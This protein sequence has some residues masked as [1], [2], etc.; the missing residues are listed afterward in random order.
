M[1]SSPFYG[2]TNFGWLWKRHAGFDV[3]T[4]NG[5][6]GN[7]TVY[8]SLGKTPEMIWVK[9]KSES[10]SWACYH[11][12]QNGGTTPWHYY[13]SLNSAGGPSGNS[14]WSVWRQSPNTTRF[15]I[16]DNW[17]ANS[18]SY[19]GYVFASVENICKVGTY[20]GSSSAITVTT[21]FQPR[22]VIIKEIS[23]SDCNGLWVVLDTN[24]G[25]GSGNDKRLD[26]GNDEA[27]VTID[28]G[29]PTSTGFTIPASSVT[30]VNRGSSHT[31]A[32]FA[33]A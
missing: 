17:N 1:L 25:W 5:T 20:S 11:K 22:F 15:Y 18:Q 23:M 26:L 33:H 29:A 19:V 9:A 13:L 7:K 27:Q 3:V 21:G 6:G 12:G 31:Y 4:W 24:R 8:H 32:Y 2:S 14:S 16:K 28:Y 10:Q 30:N